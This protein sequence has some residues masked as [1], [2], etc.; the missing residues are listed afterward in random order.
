MDI[1]CIDTNTIVPWMM[2]EGEI[3]NLLIQKYKLSKDFKQ[4]Y[5]DRHQNSVLFI[6]EIINQKKSGLLKD[7]F[8][9]SYLAMNEVYSSIRDEIRSIILF[10]RGSPLSRWVEERNNIDLPEECTEKIY[11]QIE[12]TFDKLFE[13]NLINP[14]SDEPEENGDNFSEIVS[15]LILKFKKVKT[16]DAILLATAISI[17]ARYFVTFDS[18]LIEEIKDKL[19]TNYGLILIKP[20]EAYNILKRKKK[21]RK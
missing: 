7:E 8:K 13:N 12:I 14:T 3:L 2:K 11:T 1:W 5:L 21:R 10:S 6:D 4:I 9:F 18:R 17:E 16:Q 15:S 19:T 20:S